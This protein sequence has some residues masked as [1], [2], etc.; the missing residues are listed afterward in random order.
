MPARARYTRSDG[1]HGSW[2]AVT[3]F[4]SSFPTASS[5]QAASGFPALLA[6]MYHDAFKEAPLEDESSRMK[7]LFIPEW[8]PS[9]DQPVNGLF[10]QEMARAAALYDDVVVLYTDPKPT[11]GCGSRCAI[12]DEQEDGLRVVRVTHGHGQNNRSSPVVPPAR[13]GSAKPSQ[14]TDAS[15][16]EVPRYVRYIGR[17]MLHYYRIHRGFRM[18]LKEGWK[19]D[20]LHA[21]VATAGVP[22]VLL[23]KLYHMPVVITEHSTA[24]P[25]GLARG[26]RRIQPKF[27]FEHADLVCPVSEGLKQSI[28]SQGIRAK[29]QVIPNVVDPALFFPPD[30][31]C[32]RT[33]ARKHL[34]VVA[35]LDPKKGIPYLLQAL[36]RLKSRRN[37]FV[38]DI[39][40]DGP[41]RTEYEELTAALGLQDT[42]RFHG[43]KPKREVAE[44][45]RNSDVMVVP[46]LV[47][48]FS[49]VAAEALTTGLPVV[50]TRCGGP[51][52]FVTPEA[53]L[54]V[55]PG[56][57][58]ALCEALD[59][60]LSTLD[61]YP[62][63][64]L[65]Q[66]GSRRFH[67][68]AV[69]AQLHAVYARLAN[70]TDEKH[71][72]GPVDSDNPAAS[73]T[74]GTC[75]REQED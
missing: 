3:R 40:G 11:Q 13:A 18:L 30:V 51:E 9:T 50:T 38:L 59:R 49:V 64:G 75:A 63:Q 29:F 31:R 16:A 7:V 14:S 8:Y 28:E 71:G 54:V 69:G 47:E 74:T 62:R 1:L 19:P 73:L 21:H 53:G 37:D 35:L 65:A 22:A 46:S 34:L 26:I 44:F 23:G 60:V 17:Q 66:Y 2:V 6:P 39:V 20:I 61:K 33:G 42:V 24:F 36:A 27:A 52:E 72:P 45:M 56:D 68:S 43:I 41:P 25:R 57:P 10:V 48:T 15:L 32:I 4:T 67:P 5:G 58:E 70:P 55:N 12:S